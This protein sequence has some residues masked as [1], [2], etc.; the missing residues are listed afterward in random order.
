MSLNMAAACSRIRE[1][2]AE[3]TGMER[4]F[5]A[6][7]DGEHGIPMALREFPAAIVFPGPDSANGYQHSAGW[8]RHTYE[9][10]VHVYAGTATTERI[11]N[12]LP[13]VD[14]I[15]DKFAQNVTLGSR[16]N[17]CR[18]LRQSGLAVLGGF[19]GVEYTGYEITL[20]VSEQ[21]EA[22]TGAGS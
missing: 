19:G 5:A 8:H 13:F 15:I 17:S 11:A 22:A 4:V 12:V 18:Y 3:V 21:S 20:E 2:V 6:S 7:E 9:V 14:R 1:L 16:V 10:Q